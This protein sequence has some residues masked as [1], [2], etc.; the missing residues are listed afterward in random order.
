MDISLVI[1]L[2]DNYE[3]SVTFIMTASQYVFSAMGKI[4]ELVFS[5]DNA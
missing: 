4:S 2:G 1:G 3:S 5:V